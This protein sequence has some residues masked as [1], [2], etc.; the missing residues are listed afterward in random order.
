MVCSLAHARNFSSSHSHRPH[1]PHT[2]QNMQ[3]KTLCTMG[4]H[5]RKT[6]LYHNQVISIQGQPRN[7]CPLNC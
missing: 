7:F 1:V 4:P 5:S 3:A 6:G 2:Q